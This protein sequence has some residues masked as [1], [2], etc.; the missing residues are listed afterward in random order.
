MA[1]LVAVVLF[2]SAGNWQQRRMRESERLRDRVEAAD[3]VATVELPA[4]VSDWTAWRFR[5]VTV[6]GTFDAVH[7][8]LVDNVIHDGR[9]GFDVVTPLTLGDGRRVLV[10][11]GW[12]PLEGS[13]ARLPMPAPPAGEVTLRGRIDI[14]T[15]HYVE[16]GGRRP[17]TGPV[18]ENLDPGRYAAAT[19]I[20]VLPIVIEAVDGRAGD[21]L[22]RQWTPADYGIVMHQGYMLQWYTFAAMVAGLWFWF[23]LRPWWRGRRSPA[24]DSGSGDGIRR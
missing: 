1:A 20:A 24:A 11:R 3:R 14:P 5:H 19:G 16:L 4:R 10:A 9:A 8:I 18:W 22:L 13:R 15:T 17:P 6:T 2:V 21:G 12:F 23:A 7:Q